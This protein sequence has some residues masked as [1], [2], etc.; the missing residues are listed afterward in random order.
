MNTTDTN[1][2]LTPTSETSTI[3]STVKDFSKATKTDVIMALNVLDSMYKNNIRAYAD[4][5]HT[6]TKDIEN[7]KNTL[8]QLL[9]EI[10]PQKSLLDT[11]EKE[12]D[13]ELRLLEKLTQEWQQSTLIIDALHEELS[14]LNHSKKERE[15]VLKNRYST[16][17][18]LKLEIKETEI[19]LL[20]HELEKQNILLSIEP[21][22][23]KIVTLTQ[24]IKKLEN[25]KRYIESAQLHQISTTPN[26]SSA[27]LIQ[28]DE[29]IDI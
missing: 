26:A 17:E 9:K 22:E 11:L 14:Q 19:K 16:L 6:C 2:A 15:S 27:P 1:T 21:T 29:I 5:L 12:L 3:D 28:N 7:S 20:S 4:A 23:S 10:A 18:K 24:H 25:Q 8:A 13:F